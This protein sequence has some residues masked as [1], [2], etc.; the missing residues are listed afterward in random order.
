MNIL[1]FGSR[2]LSNASPVGIILGGTALAMAVPPLR[3]GLRSVAVVATRGV[4]SIADEAKRV[5]AVSRE[6]ME[7]MINEAKDPDT[8]FPSCT[9]FKESVADLKTQPRRLAVAATMGALTVSDKAK[10]LYK[11]ASEQIKNIVDEAKNPNVSSDLPETDLQEAVIK[12]KELPVK[13]IKKTASI[14]HRSEADDLEL[15]KHK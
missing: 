1:R 2:L 3:Q 15:P 10:S 12:D 5:T 8:C 9:D 7:D 14:H 13:K 6:S 4:L 11:D